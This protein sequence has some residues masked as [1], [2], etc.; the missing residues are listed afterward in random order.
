[1]AIGGG[2]FVI[3][4]YYSSRVFIWNSVPKSAG[5]PADL[6]L[7]QPDFSSTGYNN[8]T[9][10]VSNRTVSSPRGLWTDGNRLVLADSGN[11]RVLI[12]NTFPTKNQQ[13][14]DV[15]L[16]QPDKSSNILNNGGISA[17]SLYTPVMLTGWGKN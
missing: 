16:G 10:G 12:W 9:G 3:S 13:P 11:H 7:G 1:L 5:V 2:K 14:A 15:V 6:I 8:D 4:S 17:K